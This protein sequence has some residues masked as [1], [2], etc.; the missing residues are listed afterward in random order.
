MDIN[1]AVKFFKNLITETED[2]SEVKIYKKFVN[3][4]VAISV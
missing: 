3:G 2:A 1:E 4:I